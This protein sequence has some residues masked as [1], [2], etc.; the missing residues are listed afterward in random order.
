[1]FQAI[2]LALL[3]VR[4]SLTPSMKRKR[5]D[6]DFS[7][8]TDRSED[9]FILRR[10]RPIDDLQ[11]EIDRLIHVQ[12]SLIKDKTQFYDHLYKFY[13][14]KGIP[15]DIDI[16]SV[17]NILVS[18]FSLSNLPT[19]DYPF[20]Y[21]ID[22]LDA[23][24]YEELQSPL[25]MSQCSSLHE[26]LVKFVNHIVESG[27][28]LLLDVLDASI[29][30][31]ILAKLSR[32]QAKLMN[33]QPLNQPVSEYLAQTVNRLFF[34]DRFSLFVHLKHGKFPQLSEFQIDELWSLYVKNISSADISTHL[35][36]T[37]DPPKDDLFSWIYDILNEIFRDLSIEA[38]T[39]TGENNHVENFII[40]QLA[41]SSNDLIKE[42]DQELT[43]ERSSYDFLKS[44]LRSYLNDDKEDEFL[45]DRYKFLSELIN[46]RLE[47]IRNVERDN[48]TLLSNFNTIKG[49]EK[50]VRSIHDSGFARIGLLNDENLFFASLA[51]ENMG[52]RNYSKSV[53]K[54]IWSTIVKKTIARITFP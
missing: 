22:D 42:S 13:K 16:N 41:R 12:S 19:L 40:S 44:M 5:S 29:S 1:M 49:I 18:S 33:S 37:V 48:P 38:I 24:I 46:K 39:E 31:I 47:T 14:E 11:P 26:C 35:P 3:L 6:T 15:L 50:Y 53:Q 28:P 36:S 45:E 7:T 8:Q 9:S 20:R 34:T 23:I 4:G 43:W 52:G 17:W 10:H 2:G 27:H 25:S 51:A 30:N 54:Y 32:I 21:G